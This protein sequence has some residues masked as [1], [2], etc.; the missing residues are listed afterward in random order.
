M[1]SKDQ[2]Q[3]TIEAKFE[4]HEAVFMKNKKQA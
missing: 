1:H 3:R 4:S 2:K